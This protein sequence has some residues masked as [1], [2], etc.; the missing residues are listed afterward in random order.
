VS[1]SSA[2]RPEVVRLGLRVSS[3]QEALLVLVRA[4]HKTGA[5]RE[6]SERLERASHRLAEAIYRGAAAP[7]SAPG[8]G[9]ATGAAAGKSDDVIDAEV[10]DAED[11][12]RN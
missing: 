5:I 7:S 4:L 3:W 12:R 6:A 1:R 9:A 11:R 8:P 10:V 2:L